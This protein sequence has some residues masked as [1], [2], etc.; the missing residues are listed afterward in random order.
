MI[1]TPSVTTVGDRIK[2]ARER[3]VIGQAEL[4]RMA[5]LSQNTLWRI[6]NGSRSPRPATIRKIATIL[7]IEPRELV[8]V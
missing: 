2:S 6:E 1:D 5:G 4:A 8:G 3:R 7:K